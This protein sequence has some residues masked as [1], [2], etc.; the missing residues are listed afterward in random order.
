[1]AELASHLCHP[2]VYEHIG[3][4]PSLEDFILDR[5]RALRGPSPAASAERWLNFVVREQSTN[6]VLGRLEATLHDS[7]AEVAFLF[8]PRHWGKGF[9]HES[10]SW[11]HAEVKR[12]YGITSFWATTVPANTRCQSLLLRSG[13]QR[14]ATGA[15]VLYSFETGDLVFHLRDAA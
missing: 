11:L 3:E 7:I 8:I 6:H 10:L 1:L 4:V 14:V 2:D 15:P 5:E 13:Y 9:A 12:T